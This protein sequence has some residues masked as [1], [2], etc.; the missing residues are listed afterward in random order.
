[1]MALLVGGVALLCVALALAAYPAERVSAEERLRAAEARWQA[2]GFDGYRIVSRMGECVQRGEFRGAEIV[3]VSRQD[4]FES[5]RT[6]E[7]LF[8]LAGRT[9]SWGLGSQRCAPGGCVCRER[10]Q[11]YTI[12]DEQLGYPLAIRL[13]KHWSVDWAYLARNPGSLQAALGC[14]SP[15]EI[16]L[17]TVLALEPLP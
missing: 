4:C 2:R 8:L 1:V 12:F 5:I 10:R 6:V 15:P 14:T 7:S 11:F 17:V 3:S 9:Q 16:D 13:R